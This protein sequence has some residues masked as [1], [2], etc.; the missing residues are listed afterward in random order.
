MAQRGFPRGPNS[1]AEQARLS[2]GRPLQLPH[3]G[4]ASFPS[5]LLDA[6]FEPASIT[7]WTDSRSETHSHIIARSE[8][9]VLGILDLGGAGSALI[10]IRPYCESL[11]WYT[12]ALDA[13]VPYLQEETANLLEVRE[14]P[15]YRFDPWKVIRA[16]AFVGWAMV[17]LGTSQRRQYY[18]EQLY[19][20]LRAIQR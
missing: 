14:H 7:P 20:A 12:H 13:G 17:P 2:V 9:V 1:P 15:T 6:G 5:E 4:S 10:Q 16:A 18:S 11:L 19:S 8:H 3:K